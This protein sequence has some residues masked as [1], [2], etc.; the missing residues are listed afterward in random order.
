MWQ[1]GRIKQLGIFLIIGLGFAYQVQAQDQ[2]V[3]INIQ[4]PAGVGLSAGGGSAA[5]SGTKG[6][7]SNGSEGASDGGVNRIAQ[8]VVDFAVMSENGMLIPLSWIKMQALENSQ[9]MIDFR[10]A[11][12]SAMKTTCYFL[13]TSTD[14]L[15]DASPVTVFPTV[16]RFNR[17]GRLIRNFVPRRTSVY[18]WI[19]VPNDP[20]MTMVIEYF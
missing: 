16:M 8:S 10:K 9:F 5:A 12:G 18:S 19:G 11:D 2:T 13:N 20:A 3:K 17:E 6:G 15:Q 4:L 1:V 7:G 14:E